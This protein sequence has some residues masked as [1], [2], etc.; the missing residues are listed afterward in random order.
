MCVC[1]PTRTDA[2][3]ALR[4][5]V[6]ARRSRLLRAFRHLAYCC[7]LSRYSRLQQHAA[8]QLSRLKACRAALR[9]WR[10]TVL[11]TR[12]LRN[13]AASRTYLVQRT[14]VLA[15][16]DHARKQRCVRAHACMWL[17]TFPHIVTEAST[18]AAIALGAPCSCPAAAFA[19]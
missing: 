7:H 1:F 12:V 2:A 17:G 10:V 8:E 18:H 9:H 5:S 13:M 11:R 19:Y 15:L 4:R 16:R 3:S 6:H 14:S